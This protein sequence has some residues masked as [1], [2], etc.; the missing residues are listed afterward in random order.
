M[1]KSANTFLAIFALL[2]TIG[3]LVM[4]MF[5]VK[6][7]V[8]QY[9]A[10]SYPSTVG[11]ITRSETT[12]S[13]VSD[14]GTT[15][16]VDIQYDYAVNGVSYHGDRYRYGAGSSS[17][18]AWAWAAVQAHPAGSE[19]VVYYR[20]NDPEESLLSVG[21]DGS[22][23]FG[24]LFVTPFNA[25][26]VGIWIVVLSRRLRESSPSV[27]GGVRIITEGMKVRA[28][29]VPCSVML[30]W[31]LA[32]GLSAFVSIFVVLIGGGGFHPSVNQAKNTWIAVITISIV[33]TVWRWIRE[34]SGL[35]D[36]VIDEASS[37]LDLPGRFLRPRRV[38]LPISEVASVEVRRVT[39]ASDS[40]NSYTYRPVLHFQEKK[41]PEAVLADWNDEEKA[42]AFAGWLRDRLHLPAKT[43]QGADASN[44]LSRSSSVG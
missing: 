6:P 22:N 2:W 24:L 28:R 34:N 37:T 23:L 39:H 4:D 18:D 21:V 27:A 9:M 7:A 30:A 15:T 29:L 31:L 8:K 14:G 12:Q 33:M 25:G 3:V 5:M 44:A 40:G 41:M 42:T 20:R 19:A 26:A 13:D 17:D 43:A 38:R 1:H 32:L 16:G 35:D 36:L 11:R 10:A